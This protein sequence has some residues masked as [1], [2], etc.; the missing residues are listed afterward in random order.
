[1]ETGISETR[2]RPNR[3]WTFLCHDELGV[4]I[5]GVTTGDTST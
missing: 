4:G 3:L 1:M 2:D 5:E